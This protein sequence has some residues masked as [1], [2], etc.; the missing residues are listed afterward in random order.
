MVNLGS[1]FRVVRC[2]QGSACEDW[3]NRYRFEPRHGN[4]DERDSCIHVGDCIGAGE[5]PRTVGDHSPELGV[6]GPLGHLYGTVMVLLF[7][8]LQM[9]PASTVAPVDKRSVVPV[10]LGAWPVTWR[11]LDVT[12][13]RCKPG[14]CVKDG[15]GRQALLMH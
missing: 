2:C 14:V 12:Q 10:I 5:A 6:S 8:A 3:R 1:S 9:G 11:T 15:A 7:R 13:W 4:P